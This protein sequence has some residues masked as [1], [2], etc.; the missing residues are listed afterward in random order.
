MHRFLIGCIFLFSLHVICGK[1]DRSND[2]FDY[3]AGNPQGLSVF[4][5]LNAVLSPISLPSSLHIIYVGDCADF[6]SEDLLPSWSIALISY[7]CLVNDEDIDTCRYSLQAD[8]RDLDF[9]RDSNCVKAISQS[10]IFYVSPSSSSFGHS[11]VNI[12]LIPFHCGCHDVLHPF[13]ITMLL[14]N[15]SLRSLG[16][17]P[18]LIFAFNCDSSNT[19]S[20]LATSIEAELRSQSTHPNNAASWLMLSG[21][22]DWN[23]GNFFSPE[24]KLPEHG[25]T[26]NYGEHGIRDHSNVLA[27]VFDEPTLRLFSSSCISAL[28]PKLT[29][30]PPNGS[31]IYCDVPFHSQFIWYFNSQL[32][33]HAKS[34]SADAGILDFR[35]PYL[36][37][38]PAFRLQF[39][40]EIPTVTLSC[41]D[42]LPSAPL[43]V[44]LEVNFESFSS[45]DVD[46][47]D[48]DNHK[49]LYTLATPCS[50]PFDQIPGHLRAAL[51]DAAI[52]NWDESNGSNEP[53]VLQVCV[54]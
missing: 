2:L 20:L 21:H 24:S 52:F 29:L 41:S 8:D 47:A 37:N 15:D 31:V 48:G 39:T 42:I 38:A 26:G 46:G 34:N 1:Y 16:S 28:A 40:Q 5:F 13:R 49:F 23:F 12:L 33:P 7:Q 35:S 18:V 4:S 27:A 25:R 45:D 54:Y 10:Q 50:L 17:L 14:F 6:L 53:P 30:V 43:M 22:C 36:T 44:P 3:Y 51:H 19:I 32:Q 11:V 9:V